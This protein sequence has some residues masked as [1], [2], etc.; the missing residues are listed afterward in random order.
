[1]KRNKNDTSESSNERFSSQ[2]CEEIR[3]DIR[4]GVQYQKIF[5]DYNTVDE[6][7]TAVAHVTGDCDCEDVEE[8]ALNSDFLLERDF[9][10]T[11]YFTIGI[12]FNVVTKLTD[13]SESEV[14]TLFY[15]DYELGTA[16]A[17]EDCGKLRQQRQAG[18]EYEQI[19]ESYVTK[20]QYREVLEHITGD[21]SCDTA[22]SRVSEKPYA[23]ETFMRFLFFTENLDFTEIGFICNRHRETIK[24]WICEEHDL[25]VVDDTERTSSKRIRN[26]QRFAAENNVS[27]DEPLTEQFEVEESVSND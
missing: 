3:R 4:V 16:I 9:L 10:R 23:D 15:D 11:V 5:E 25:A 19:L 26:M 20:E 2:L 24:T 12:D 8:N 13:V 27:L 17:P 22:V 7:Q 1:M 21:C 14:E 6:L 18:V